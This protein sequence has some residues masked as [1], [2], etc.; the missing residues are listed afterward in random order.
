M[1]LMTYISLGDTTK[2]ESGNCFTV[3]AGSHD[4]SCLGHA[5][6]PIESSTEKW[7]QWRSV[8]QLSVQRANNTHANIVTL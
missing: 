8:A 6:C 7:V 2:S 4:H 5:G 1:K 3:H